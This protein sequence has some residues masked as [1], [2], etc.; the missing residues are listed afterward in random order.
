M[1]KEIRENAREASL[2]VPL[3]RHSRIGLGYG[4]ISFP[5]S[6]AFNLHLFLCMA[7]AG[8]ISLSFIFLFKSLFPQQVIK[9]LRH[10]RSGGRV[11]RRELTIV[12]D[13]SAGHDE[14]CHRL[15]RPITYL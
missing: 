9:Y 11:C 1:R 12:T 4:P 2:E 5:L 13:D 10:F 14:G 15:S 3:L 8:Q 6:R 7:Q